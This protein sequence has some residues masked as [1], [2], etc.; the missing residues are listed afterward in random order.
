MRTDL[1]EV[2]VPETLPQEEARTGNDH[3]HLALLIL[4]T[5]GC[6]IYHISY[7]FYIIS[8]IMYCSEVASI[9]SL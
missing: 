7:L 3:Q 6:W 1:Q 5:D 4:P 8:V 9:E 2:P